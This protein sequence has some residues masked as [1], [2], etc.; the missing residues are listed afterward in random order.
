MNFSAEELKKLAGPLVLFVVMLAAGAGLI[1]WL[2]QLQVVAV[3]ELATARNERGQADERLARIAEE[4]KEVSDKLAVYQRLKSLRILGEERRLEWADA[5][6]RI[7]AGREL[8]EP[9]VYTAS[10]SSRPSTRWGRAAP[11]RRRRSLRTWKCS[12]AP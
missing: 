2:Q 5:M 7:S 3:G 6:R 12:R 9:P 4:E 1:F 8:L 10:C 11:S